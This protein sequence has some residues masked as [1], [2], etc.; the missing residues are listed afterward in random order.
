MVYRLDLPTIDPSR[1]LYSANQTPAL[2]V[3]STIELSQP[4][5]ETEFEWDLTPSQMGKRRFSYSD[6]A[7]GPAAKRA[8]EDNFYNPDVALEQA[9]SLDGVFEGQDITQV[10]AALDFTLPSQNSVLSDPLLD[11]NFAVDLYDWNCSTAY[12]SLP[13]LDFASGLGNMDFGEFQF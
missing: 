13:E 9:V 10:I 6:E 1:L 5:H 7:D 8:R 11:G 4:Y 12:A 2:S 3:P